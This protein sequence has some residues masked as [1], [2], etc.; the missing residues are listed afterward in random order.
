MAPMNA[1]S[2]TKPHRYAQRNAVRFDISPKIWFEPVSGCHLSKKRKS[3]PAPRTTRM[4]PTR[5]IQCIQRGLVRFKSEGS[6]AGS[7]TIFR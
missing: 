3:D 5:F 7:T 6:E 2:E 1:I 4:F